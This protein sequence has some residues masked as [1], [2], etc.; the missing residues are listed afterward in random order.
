MADAALIQVLGAVAYGEQKAY[1]EARQ[2][3]DQATDPGDRRM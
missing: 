2:F 3:A 1:E